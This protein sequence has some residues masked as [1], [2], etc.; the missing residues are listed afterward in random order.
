MLYELDG[1]LQIVDCGLWIVDCGLWIV[2]CGS[3][4][5][6]AHHWY[7]S[8]KPIYADLDV[9][10]NDITIPG[11]VAATVVEHPVSGL[12]SQ[13]I[14]SQLPCTHPDYHPTRWQ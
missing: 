11:V 4:V 13:S 6:F 9:G 5:H 1:E 8:R 2:D 14:L 3:T 10:Q 12:H 7:P